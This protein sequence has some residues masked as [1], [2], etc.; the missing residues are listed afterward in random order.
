M[1][2]SRDT[3]TMSA[4]FRSKTSPFPFNT[5][6]V[7]DQAPGSLLIV[8]FRLTALSHICWWLGSEGPCMAGA[9][10]PSN[11]DRRNQVWIDAPRVGSTCVLRIIVTNVLEISAWVVRAF[12]EG[13]L[14][15]L[16][17][18]FCSRQLPNL[19]HGTVLGSCPTQQSCRA[20]IVSRFGSVVRVERKV[21]DGVRE[22]CNAQ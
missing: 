15:V 7:P 18:G 2:P 10:T 20:I 11:A 22:I 17:S 4:N 6:M 14:T 13:V 3:T 9:L 5:S 16:P 19:L 21:W 1:S 12:E 8:G